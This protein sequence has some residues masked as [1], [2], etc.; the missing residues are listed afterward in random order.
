MILFTTYCCLKMTPLF[1]G[2]HLPTLRR[3]PKTEVQRLVEIKTK[4]HK[5]TL[6]EMGRCLGRYIP[7]SMF[8]RDEKASFSR[9]RI[10]SLENTFWG[11]FQQILSSDGGC[12]EIV[13][14]F[15]ILATQR[16][17]QKISASTSAYCQARKK[18]E[19]SLLE[20]IFTHT[21][22][23]I[24][25]NK[26]NHPLVNRRVIVVDG[27]GVSMSDTETNQIVWPQ[28]KSQKIGCGFPQAKICA[29]FDL[30]TG[31]ALSYRIGNKKSHEIPLLREQMQTFNSGDIFLG[32][33]GFISYFDML[34]LK[35]KGVDSVV[36][37][38]RRKPIKPCDA[39]HIL[40]ENDLIVEW[41]KPLGSKTRYKLDEWEGLPDKLLIRQIKVSVRQPGFRVKEFYI[42]TTLLDDKKYPSKIIAELY[43]KRWNV[44]LYFRELKTTLGLDILR[45]KTPDMIKKEILMYFIVY[46][47]IKLL[48]NDGVENDVQ[49]DEM[50]F[51]SCRQV[52]NSYVLSLSG[53]T[54]KELIKTNHNKNLCDEIENCQLLKRFGRVEPRVLKRRPKP[55]RLMMKPRAE[56]KA[57]LMGIG[58][59]QAALT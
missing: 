46:N 20:N 42:A 33:K 4:I 7:S 27:T 44:E 54:E 57:E 14:Q 31:I 1:P 50:S 17:S 15:R 2:W 8:Y 39:K 13:N 18:L 34:N 30:K 19:H 21:Q 22:E 9:R 47:T 56:L 10:F 3:K 24:S 11:F 55:Y 53:R 45:C 16:G 37:L 5:K 51:K 59:W 58:S 23:N 43:L 25:A 35:E 49:P 12:K 36:G 29:L 28:P 6:S 48:A 52:L 32:D 38:A 41:P 40:S 26:M